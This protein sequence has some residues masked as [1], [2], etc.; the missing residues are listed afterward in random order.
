MGRSESDEE[1][2]RDENVDEGDFDDGSDGHTF[3]S[4][5]SDGEN[6]AAVKETD[7]A[8]GP[9]VPKRKIAKAIEQL[10]WSTTRRFLYMLV[11]SKYFS[12]FILSC[13]MLNTIVMTLQTVET[14]VRKYSYYTQIVDN[15]FFGCYVF[16]M[17]LKQ[18]VYR[19]KYFQS[20]WNI[21]DMFIVMTSF[22]DYLTDAIRASASFNPK[23]L[24][25][26]RLQPTACNVQPHF[27]AVA[28]RLQR[29]AGH[30]DCSERYE[31]S[32]R[33]ACYARS[34]S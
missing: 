11:E 26:N 21:F 24:R 17:L 23:I 3:S 10:E 14:I 6:D 32:A 8:P 29:V 27:K 20:G 1:S 30:S 19:R 31:P 16:E 33:C 13:I 15:I 12:G 4:A 28:R 22:L 34:P 9:V 2:E 25:C 7:D 5:G 18:I